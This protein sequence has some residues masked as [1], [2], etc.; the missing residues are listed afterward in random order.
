MKSLGSILTVAVLTAAGCIS[1]PNRQDDF[2]D[3]NRRQLETLQEMQRVRATIQGDI[4]KLELVERADVFLGQNEVVVHLYFA[5][6]G[7]VSLEDKL[8]VREK[9]YG[10]VSRETGLTEDKIR[11]LAKKRD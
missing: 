3:A 9:V 8:A 10:I 6:S 4:E 1:A 2:K 7:V 11:L 5:T